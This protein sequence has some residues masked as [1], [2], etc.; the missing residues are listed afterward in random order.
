[1]I[2]IGKSHDVIKYIKKIKIK[3]N[4]D[5]Y[6]ED[7][8]V[9][10]FLME[11]NKS[12]EIFIYCEELIFS[13][14][15]KNIVQYFSKNSKQ[16]YTVSKK[17]YEEIVTKGFSAGVIGVYKYEFTPLEKVKD[18]G[19]VVVLDG[20][21]TP[22]NLGTIIRTCD[23]FNVDAII[24]V[25]SRTNVFNP[26]VVQSSRGMSLF[27]PIVNSTYEEAQKFLLDNNYDIY[28]GE[29]E[30]GKSYLDYD[31]HN[32]TALVFGNERFGINKKWYDN[33]NLKLYVPMYGK[34]TSLNV[35]VAASIV[36]AY[37]GVKRHK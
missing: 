10:N 19:F 4:E 7:L 31:Y 23:S 27:V 30:L 33:K 18:K 20:L 3:S 2:N 9:L 34:M 6:I 35:C 17:L 36:I 12:L 5:I 11:E 22:G 14:D 8:S 32:K 37:T 13:E 29:P 26:K 1:M 21:E 16:I 25:D 24:L 15:A 28:L